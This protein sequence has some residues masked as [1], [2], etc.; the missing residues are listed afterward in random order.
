[1][2]GNVAKR[3]GVSKDAARDWLTK[4]CALWLDKACRYCGRELTVFNFSIDHILPISRGGTKD[5]DGCQLICKTCN[6]TKGDFTSE[7]FE[8]TYEFAKTGGE[9]F[10]K[11][12]LGK[13]RMG[14][15]IFNRGRR[16]YAKYDKKT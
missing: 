4:Q 13:L 10:A 5:L 8:K 16:R 1:M 3:C 2:S 7:E 11:R 15:I 12:L 14:G 6:I 9:E